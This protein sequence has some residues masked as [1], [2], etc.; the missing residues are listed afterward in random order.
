MATMQQILAIMP[1][2]ASRISLWTDPLNAAMVECDATT[3]L[4]Q[5]YFLAI[6]ARETGELSRLDEN[7]NYSA[8]R[9]MQVWPSIGPELATRLAHN[10]EALANYIYADA[11]RPPG[12]RM[13]NT[14]PGDGWKYRGMGIPQLT[15]H[16]LIEAVLKK[17]GRPPGDTAYLLTPEGACRGMAVY[18]R[19]RGLNAYADADNAEGFHRAVN[20]G[21][22]G[23]DAFMR[24]L[25]AAKK[26]LQ[27]PIAA[28]PDAG[29]LLLPGAHGERVTAL[30]ARLN[31]RHTPLLISGEFDRT[32]ELAVRLFQAQNGLDPDGKVGPA[33]R[34]ALGLKG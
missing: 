15:G 23:F 34:A 27:G 7:L 33:T 13:G 9:M 11:N 5:A 31:E 1:N 3:P 12:Y 6:T 30:Q 2:A 20:G 8:E 21:M 16:D 18:W 22:I 14:R 26:A 32:T 4:R 19:D 17:L 29:S 25:A 28:P 10:P 24:Y